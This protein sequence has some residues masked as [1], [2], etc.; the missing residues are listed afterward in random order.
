MNPGIA[1][2]DA[3]DESALASE[4]TARETLRDAP[5]G[6]STEYPDRYSPALLFAVPR[7][8]QRALLG[9][10][11]ELPFTGVDIW[12]AYDMTWL[13]E[14]GKPHVAL[15]TIEVPVASTHL[16]E[17]KSMK[18]YLGSFAQSRFADMSAVLAAIERDVSQVVGMQVNATLR[19]PQ[20]FDGEAIR[21]LEGE[22][23]DDLA[24]ACDVYQ[25]DPTL[26]AASG[27]TVTETLTTRLFRSLCPVTGQPDI[28]SIQIRYRGAQIDH[29]SLLRYLVSYRCH[30]GF[31]E[32][33]VERIFV[34][35]RQRCCCTQL[36]VLARF[37]RRG[38]LD[39]NPFRTN[40]DVPVP[41]NVRTARQ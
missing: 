36:S 3:R 20:T 12:T 13:D 32:H 9:I 34:D 21:E 37:T 24:V 33:C 18:L 2:N 25:V 10:A 16:V 39:I 11:D 7:A 5:L 27:D 40:A 19:G 29:E 38:G 28:A 8:P 1:A 15:A 31:H 41:A 4:A 17:S 35:V 30:A 6:H 26:L 14:R 22:S 23:L